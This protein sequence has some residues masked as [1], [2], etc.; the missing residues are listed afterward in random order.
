VCLFVFVPMLVVPEF[1]PVVAALDKSGEE[2]P[3]KEPA[4]WN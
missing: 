4:D 2:L 1:E 3:D